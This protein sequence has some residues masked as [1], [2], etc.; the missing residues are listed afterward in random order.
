MRPS[1]PSRS[2]VP[3]NLKVVGLACPLHLF[4]GST[5]NFSFFPGL[6]WKL[7]DTS[8]A[9][10]G[11]SSESGTPHI[12]VQL[13]EKLQAVLFGICQDPLRY[14]CPGVQEL[15]LWFPWCPQLFP[16]LQGKGQPLPLSCLEGMPKCPPRQEENESCSLN[17]WGKREI[18]Q[19]GKGSIRKFPD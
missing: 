6:S 2:Q 10:L 19:R 18:D 1:A 17:G 5:L 7:R 12:P 16:V 15:S 14:R 3:D 11:C 13:A 9:C 4:P 8:E